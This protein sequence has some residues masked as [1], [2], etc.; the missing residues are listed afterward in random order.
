MI[1]SSAGLLALVL[2]AACKAPEQRACPESKCPPAPAAAAKD[3][4]T[5]KLVEFSAVPG[6]ADDKL[7]DAV[8]SLLASCA[9]LN[10]LADDALIGADPRYGTASAWRRVCAEAARVPAGDH[11]AARKL[12]EAELRPFLAASGAKGESGRMTGYYVASLRG[13]RKKHG[14]YTVPIYARPPELIDI[15]VGSFMPELKG[16]KLWG[17]LSSGAFVPYTTRGEIA[18]GALAGRGLE[19]LWVDDPADALFLDIQGSGKVALDD[20]T[21]V[22][23]KYAGKNGHPYRGVG[24]TLL[25]KGL[26]TKSEA[27][28][29]GIRAWFAANPTR[30]DEIA[31]ENRSKVFFAISDKPG[32]IGAQGVIL[33]DRRSIAVDPLYVAYST[34]V[35]IETKAPG[36]GGKGQIDL[37]QLV[38]AQDTG[39][40]I[41]GPVRADIYYGDD[42]EAGEV[43][44]RMDSLGRYWILL[45]R[46]L[47]GR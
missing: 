45:P 6:W 30:F 29:Q 12:F 13:S 17:Q 11:A 23:L 47:D 9:A 38:I 32:A 15:D 21:E 43:A 36:P 28:M 39:S 22:W 24:T 41:V 26:M 34:P 46:S 19:L 40:A 37:R 44:G 27:S 3:V 42:H 8:P 20:G 5:L 10:N 18:A 35:F 1:R 25:Q 2:V 31:N 33:T 7:A 16:K 4:V 14:A